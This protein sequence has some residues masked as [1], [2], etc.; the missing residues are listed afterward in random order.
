VIA[1]P[2]IVPPGTVIREALGTVDFKPTLLSL[3]GLNGNQEMEGRDASELFRSGK[4]P[5]E[6][7]D[8]TFVRIGG[9]G[10]GTPGWLATFTQRYKL[11]VSPT[12]DPA[13]FD[14]ES[15]PFEMQNLFKDDSRR[16]LIRDLASGLRQYVTSSKDPHGDSAAVMADLNWAVS[17]SPAYAAPV[18]EK[19]SG[20]AGE[21]D[22]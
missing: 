3:L 10:K 9:I 18:R 12:D 19:R 6:W 15:D 22:E 17:A 13:L 1:A 2:G 14:L 7:I 4:A 20:K 11:V 21:R 8:R 5:G 16:E